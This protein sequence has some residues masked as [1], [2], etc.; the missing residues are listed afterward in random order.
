MDD[1]DIIKEVPA[2]NILEVELDT[3]LLTLTWVDSKIINDYKFKYYVF[4]QDHQKSYT[5]IFHLAIN[6]L[7]YVYWL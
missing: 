1:E 2:D 3:H 7:Y 4:C 6:T 5:Y